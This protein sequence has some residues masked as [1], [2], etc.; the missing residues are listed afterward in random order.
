M[1]ILGRP[2]W[3]S[4]VTGNVRSGY[5][6]NI[7]FQAGP[8]FWVLA[9]RWQLGC[10]WNV[11]FDFGP[12]YLSV[13]VVSNLVHSY[14]TVQLRIS[15]QRTVGFSSFVLDCCVFC[16]DDAIVPS[17]TNS[18]FLLKRLYVSFHWVICA[19]MAAFTVTG[20]ISSMNLRTG[21]LCSSYFA[22]IPTRIRSWYD[23]SGLW[24]D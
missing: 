8:R 23:I 22:N 16:L 10:W 12:D 24:A 18:S 1:L 19:A 7:L 5:I 17:L 6:R 13:D 11:F 2:V 15:I 20:W 14:F 9:L 3:F 4:V 21:A